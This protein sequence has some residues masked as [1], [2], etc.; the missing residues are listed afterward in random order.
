[1]GEDNEKQSKGGK[2]RAE[3]LTPERRKEIARLAAENRW[4]RELPQA[5]HE[6]AIP[7]GASELS[8][9][10][11][12]ETRV[13]T[14]ATFLRAMGRAR[15][16][17]AGTGVLANVDELP[18]F[19]SSNVFKPFISK[20]LIESTKP[21]FYRTKTGGKGVGYDAR[22]L[23]L[24]AE[25]Y[26]RFRD[27]QLAESG[28][29]PERY[30]KMIVAADAIIRALAHVGII[31]LVDEATGYQDVRAKDALAKIFIE[32]LAAERQKWVKTFPLDFYKE[33]YRL[34]GW[35]FEPWNTK[36]PS[37]VAHW[38]D[39]FV[40]DRLAPG[41]TEELRTLNPKNEESGRRT[42]K[43]HQWFNP[44]NGHPK[45]KEHISG[46]IALLRAADDWEAFKRGIDRAYPRFKETMQLAL[47]D[48]P[49]RK[50]GKSI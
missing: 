46:V 14:Q 22:L 28:S 29:V 39:D 1:M 25:V 3:K 49:A 26:L 11:V 8:C 18:F 21:I 23:P 16:P 50:P 47:D 6:G 5:S 43:H 37:L 35:K 19:L 2:A 41:I 13:I 33:V 7:L 31:A 24:T 44:D 9:A 48:K 15:S 10:I 40:Y 42:H 30:Q 12:G 20:E 36:R 17:K 32:F 27:A 45:L 38:T 4:S 34:R